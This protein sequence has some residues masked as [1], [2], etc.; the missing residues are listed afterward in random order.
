MAELVVFADNTNGGIITS[1]SATYTIAR[2]GAGLVAAANSVSC[3]QRFLSSNYTCIETF[4]D[5]DASTLDDSVTISAVVL[6]IVPL[7]DASTTDFTLTA[8]IKDYSTTLTTAD[9]V[10]GADLAALTTVA[11]L[12][13]SGLVVDVYNDFTNVAFPANLSKTTNTR[14]I[15]YS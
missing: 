3:G 4:L 12:S 9:W 14:I 5:F 2:S 7:E 13:T 6:S 1:T 15:I 11:T 10:A 8:A